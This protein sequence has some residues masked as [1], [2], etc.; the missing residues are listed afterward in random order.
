MCIDLNLPTNYGD[1]TDA[2]SIS[3]SWCLVVETEG[4]CGVVMSILYL[5]SRLVRGSGLLG[6]AY[7]SI[8]AGE[9]G[10]VSRITL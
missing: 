4:A 1:E 6:V 2:V 3:L 7:L 9:H 10:L 5:G 8:D